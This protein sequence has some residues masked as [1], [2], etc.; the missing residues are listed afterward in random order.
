MFEGD[1]VAGLI[2]A[3][4]GMFHPPGSLYRL[5]RNNG[6]LL[7][8]IDCQR[9]SWPRSRSRK[10]P[11]ELEKWAGCNF[12]AHMSSCQKFSEASGEKVEKFL[13]SIRILRLSRAIIS[14]NFFAGFKGRHFSYSV[15]ETRRERT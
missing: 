2:K 8:R 15:F 3:V 10:R 14:G 12:W 5:G 6:P 11:N 4:C 9:T 7:P 1:G 13:P